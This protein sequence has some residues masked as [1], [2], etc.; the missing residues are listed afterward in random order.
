[1]K[2]YAQ[3]HEGRH[4]AQDEIKENCVRQKY[5]W[6]AQAKGNGLVDV[7]GDIMMP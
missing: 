7:L 4:M 5:G 6:G 3:G 2:F 1:M